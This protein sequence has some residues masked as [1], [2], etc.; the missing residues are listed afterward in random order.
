MLALSDTLVSCGGDGAI[1]FWSLAGEPR[2][3]GDL[4]AH[5]GCVLGALS[6][7]D[8]LVSWGRDGSIRF[9]SLTGEPRP[10]GGRSGPER[11]GPGLCL[12]VQV[13]TEDHGP[14]RRE[15]TPN[16]LGR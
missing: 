4:K 13:A 14:L 15:Q 11:V 3:G 10:G 16:A 5:G 12:P 2:P 9:W 8:G 7:P 6:L 1:R